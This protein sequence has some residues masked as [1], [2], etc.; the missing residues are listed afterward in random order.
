MSVNGFSGIEL[1]CAA[2]GVDVDLLAGK[3]RDQV[4]ASVRAIGAAADD[5]DHVIDVIE[6]QPVAFQDVLSVFRL[7]QQERRAPAH[8]VDAVFDEVANRLH[9]AHF[10]WLVIGD[11]QEDHAEALL[12]LRVL[13]ELVEHDLRFGASLQFDDDAHTVA[14]GFIANVADVV[15]HFVVG[16]FG[17]ALD[18]ARLVHLVRNFGDHDGLASAADVL[19]RS[20]RA[21]HEAAAPS[22]VGVDNAAFAVDESAGGEVRSLHELHH[23]RQPGLGIVHQRDGGVDDLSEVVRRDVGRHTD[24]DT[25]GAVYD[26]VRITRR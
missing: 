25:V 8:H 7:G 3:V 22:L 19:D 24:G 5:G 2:R 12:H 23:F 20:L 14:I 13:V 26:Q 11:G 16:E 18:H 9:Q 21:H 1:R 4:L 15:D 10:F 17:D 6:R